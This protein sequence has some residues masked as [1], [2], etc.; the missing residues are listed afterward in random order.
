MRALLLLALA[1]PLGAQEIYDLLLKNGNVIDPANHRNGRFDLAVTGNNIV[2]VGHDLP[3]SHARIVVDAGQFYV[4][5]GLIDINTHFDWVDW[6]L[7]LKPDAQALPSGVTTAVDAGGSSAKRFEEFK[8]TVIDHSR[9][10]LLAFLYV[11]GDLAAAASML[12]K[13][14]KVIVGVKTRDTV[15]RTQ[16][17][18]ILMADSGSTGLQAGDIESR[19]YGK[20]A[21]LETLKSARNRGVLLDVGHGSDGFWFRTAVPLIQKGFLP[22]TISSGIDKTSIMLPRATMINTISKLLNIG[23]TLEQAIERSTTNPARA[24]NRTELGTLSEGAI[25]DIAV[26]ELQPGKFGFL[27]SGH[28]KLVGDKNLACV[29]TIRNGQVVWDTQGLS[30][31]DTSRA[32]PYSNFK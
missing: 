28:G 18:T 24:I 10:R 9:T 17:K 27:D 11:D 20:D 8:K 1:L 32:G 16:M 13:Y 29:L 3:A 5:P 2:R 26:F 15:D 25:A 19:M 30:L 31:P 14:P 4:T 7:G 21:Q 6:E 23:M 12:Q 22:D